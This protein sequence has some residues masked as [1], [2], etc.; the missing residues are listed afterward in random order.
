MIGS[1]PA[2]SPSGWCA[3]MDQSLDYVIGSATYCTNQRAEFR[4]VQ[5]AIKMAPAKAHLIIISDSQFVVNALSQGFEIKS[6]S[7]RRVRNHCYA[8]A[9][10]KK[11]TVEMIPVPGKKGAKGRMVDGLAKSAKKLNGKIKHRLVR[12][13]LAD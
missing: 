10:A 3:I 7:L 6:D 1:R 8:L 13:Q 9:E 11:I 12:K 4:A 2:P 5:A